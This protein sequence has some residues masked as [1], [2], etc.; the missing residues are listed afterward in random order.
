MRGAAKDTLVQACFPHAAGSA[1]QAVAESAPK[2]TIIH[3]QVFSGSGRRINAIDVF[4]Y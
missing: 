1:I 3:P 2:T 4:Y